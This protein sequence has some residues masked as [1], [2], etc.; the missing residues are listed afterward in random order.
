MVLPRS[1]RILILLAHDVFVR[2]N[3]RAV[4]MMF[5]RLSVRL[6][7]CLERACIAIIRH[8]LAYR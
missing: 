3:R 6:P 8:T 1:D 7:V 4:A 5:V 2:T